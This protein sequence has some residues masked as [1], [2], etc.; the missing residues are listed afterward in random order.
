MRGVLTLSIPDGAGGTTKTFTGTLFGDTGQ[1]VSGEVV[2]QTGQVGYNESLTDP[3][4]RGQILVLTYPLIGSYG[5][6]DITAKDINGLSQNFESDSI[7]LQ[8]LVVGEYIDTPSHHE[9]VTTLD[10]WL[11]TEGVIGIH[12][13]DTRA[14]VEIIREHGT[15]HGKSIDSYT[16]NLTRVETVKAPYLH[17]IRYRWLKDQ[18]STK[19]YGLCT[20]SSVTNLLVLVIY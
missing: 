14:L 7:H 17:G 18:R 11:R 15:L 19:H 9:S 16:K 13:V 2:F 3:S 10:A 20:L 12:G 8:A 5:V 4:Y 6:P 1:S